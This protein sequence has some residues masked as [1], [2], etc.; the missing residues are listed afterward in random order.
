MMGG[1]AT[2][3]Q[4]QM[5]A[6]GPIGHN[7]I[8]ALRELL[9]ARGLS[10]NRASAALEEL[11]RTLP[12]LAFSRTMKGERRIDVDELVAL[13]VLLDVNPSALLFPRHVAPNDEIEL[14]PKV[15]RAAGPVWGWAD[16]KIPLPGP[17][18]RTLTEMATDFSRYARPDFIVREPEPALREVFQLAARLESVQADPDGWPERRDGLIRAYRLLGIMLEELVAKEDA[19]AGVESS[20]A[21]AQ[22]QIAVATEATA[23]VTRPEPSPHGA[24]TTRVT[25]PFG[26][27]NAK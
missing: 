21:A 19:R 17:T 11:G 2:T 8:A 14:T 27:R 23:R 10:F 26:E 6:P 9:E 1:M 12:P 4:S 22:A 24:A 25:D 7:L 15:H 20:T 3:G 18:Q 13:A 5:P 16:G